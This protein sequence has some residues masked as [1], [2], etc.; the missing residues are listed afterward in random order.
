MNRVRISRMQKNTREWLRCAVLLSLLAVVVQSFIPTAVQGQSEME[1]CE[2]IGCDSPEAKACGSGGEG[3]HPNTPE[4][5]TRDKA[6]N[7]AVDLVEK[8]LK[9]AL[10]MLQEEA[11]KD[12]ADPSSVKDFAQTMAAIKKQVD[13][14]NKAI[15][16]WDRVRGAYCMPT[17]LSNKIKKYATEKNDKDPS[18]QASCNEMCPALAKYFDDI[19]GKAGNFQNS[20]NTDCMGA[21]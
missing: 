18:Y 16:F 1:K 20:F 21:C 8:G 11:S 4:I 7:E 6:R 10:K 5:N 9:D 19:L 13:Q 3:R 14:L 15:K 2:G 17:D 12:S